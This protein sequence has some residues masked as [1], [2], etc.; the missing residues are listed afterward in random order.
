MYDFINLNH[1][2][3]IQFIFLLTEKASYSS[4]LRSLACLFSTPFLFLNL[5]FETGQPELYTEFQLQP[6]YSVI[7][8]T[9]PYE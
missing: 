9:L 3:K 7:I 8:K 6:H 4:A 2:A 5:L 1:A